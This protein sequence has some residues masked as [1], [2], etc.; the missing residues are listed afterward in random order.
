MDAMLG[1]LVRISRLILPLMEIIGS[2]YAG[3]PAAPYNMFPFFGMV[4]ENGSWYATKYAIRIQYYVDITETNAIGSAE[5]Y[6]GMK[7]RV[8]EATW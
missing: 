8:R 5:E 1:V 3:P 4:C 7:S 6:A 2:P